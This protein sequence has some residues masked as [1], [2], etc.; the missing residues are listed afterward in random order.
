MGKSSSGFGSGHHQIL[1]HQTRMVPFS[2]FLR[3]LPLGQKQLEP[4]VKGHART[5]CHTKPDIFISVYDFYD[6]QHGWFCFEFNSDV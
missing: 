4:S 1:G 3:R 2:A 6:T 5:Q